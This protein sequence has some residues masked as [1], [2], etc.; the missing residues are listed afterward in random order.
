MKKSAF[1]RLRVT[2]CKL[3]IRADPWEN[4]SESGSDPFPTAP[5]DPR[6]ESWT[7]LAGIH[8]EVTVGSEGIHAEA[9]A[10]DEGVHAE[11]TASDRSN[12]IMAMANGK[13]S[14]GVEMASIESGHDAMV[15]FDQAHLVGGRKRKVQ[16][17]SPGMEQWQRRRC[18]GSRKRFRRQ[19]WQP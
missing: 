1:P 10:S 14:H 3:P 16:R 17:A 2:C 4:R 19:A 6:V 7:A 15:L 12:C 5:S 18:P 13:G 9:M 8:A 11:A